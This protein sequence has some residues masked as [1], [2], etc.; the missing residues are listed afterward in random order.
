[1]VL[2]NFSSLHNSSNNQELRKWN[3][4]TNNSNN[5]KENFITKENIRKR[6]RAVW[7]ELMFSLNYFN[8]VTWTCD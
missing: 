8:F 2:V 6:S 1:M 3:C 7:T 5:M 4:M